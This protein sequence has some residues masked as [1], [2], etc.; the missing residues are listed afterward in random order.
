MIDRKTVLEQPE[1]N[2]SGVLGVKLAFLL[3]E[4][5]VEVDDPKWHRTVIPIGVDAR[6]QM[7]FVNAH[8][9]AMEPPMPPVP[10]EDIDFI[11]QCHAL[12]EQRYAQ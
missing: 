8:L 12:M 6:A 11:V 3:V 7:E 2:R 10:P 1:L 5:G 4:G 9:A